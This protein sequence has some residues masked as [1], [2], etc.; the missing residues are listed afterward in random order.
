MDDFTRGPLQAQA[1]VSR[2]PT[3]DQTHAG[4]RETLYARSSHMCPG[5]SEDKREH[6]PTKEV[7][8]H[9]RTFH[10]EKEVERDHQ[11]C[12]VELGRRLTVTSI[13]LH[14]RKQVRSVP[15]LQRHHISCSRAC[16]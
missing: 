7:K 13:I 16:L 2:S 5:E 15:S 10:F 12:A 1:Q 14:V 11:N 3:I 9:L 4:T 6:A 8:I